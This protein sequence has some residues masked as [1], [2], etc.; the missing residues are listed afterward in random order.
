MRHLETYENFKIKESFIP[1]YED[2]LLICKYNKN[3]YENKHTVQG[4]NIS[5]FNYR[6][7]D[8]KDFINPIPGKPEINAKEMRGIC[9]IFNEDG[10]IYRSY[11]HLQKF[12]N[13]NQVEETQYDILKDYKIKSVANKL[14]G[15]LITFVELPNGN[16]ISKT[17]NSFDNEQTD[18]TNKIFNENESI[19]NFINWCDKKNYVALFEYVSFMNKVVLNYDEPQLILLRVRNNSTG[20]YIDF[21][22]L[23][24]MGKIKVAE[25]ENFDSLD[26]IIELSKNIEDKEGWVIIL[27]DD[28]GKYVMVKQKTDWYFIKHRLVDSL[29]RENDIISLVLNNTI[30]DVLSQLVPS[31]DSNKIEFINNITKIVS[32]WVNDR[33]LGVEDLC[34]KYDGDL[35]EFAIKYKK[36]K[37][38]HMSMLVIRNG[39]DVFDVVK[40]FLR[41][42]TR[43]LEQARKFI[44]NKNL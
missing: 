29:E 13:I 40:E 17:Q 37:N 15:S 32:D 31:K 30:D 9:F 35:R 1:T 43:L 42:R 4:Y 34:S 41:Y 28:E 27:E 36:D 25:S 21:S 38:F 18:I 20:E 5:T 23:K 10:S 24:D 26:D 8:Y 12:W 11:L 6:I 14:D 7:A 39:E 2:C 16:V 33:V 22:N 3:F 44:K 19:K